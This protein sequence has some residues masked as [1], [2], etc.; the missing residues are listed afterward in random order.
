MAFIE[1]HRLLK[2]GGEAALVDW[3]LT[4]TFDGSNTRH[5]ELRNQIETFERYSG[6]S[7]FPRISRIA[8]KCWF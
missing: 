6:P 7:K 2:P 4:D 3:T 5:N 1:L 8:T